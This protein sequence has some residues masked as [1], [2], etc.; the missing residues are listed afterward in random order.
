M[1]NNL[2]YKGK[3]TYLIKT[4]AFIHWQTKYCTVVPM[5]LDG[6]LC[7]E[8]S[9]VTFLIYFASEENICFSIP[10]KGF[11]KIENF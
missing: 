3:F 4:M 6:R 5:Y 8:S 11:T 1:P 2:K 10:K 7:W 9:Y